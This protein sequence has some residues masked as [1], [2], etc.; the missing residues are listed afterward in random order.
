VNAITSIDLKGKQNRENLIE[1][2]GD[3]YTENDSV[4]NNK[5]CHS[6]QGSEKPKKPQ[7]HAMEDQNLKPEQLFSGS[8]MNWRNNA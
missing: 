7:L 3:H 2:F 8:P 5:M 1:I 4:F 6:A